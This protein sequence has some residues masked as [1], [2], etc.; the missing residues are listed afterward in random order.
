MS[1]YH[2]SVLAYIASIGSLNADAFAACFAADCELNDPVGAPV[3]HGQAGAHAFYSGIAQLLSKIEM[4]PVQVN[5][6]GNRAAF[7]WTMHA[8]GKAGQKAESAGID[9]LEFDEAG[10]IVRSWG[11][12]NPGPFVAALS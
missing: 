12:W 3:I 2:D 10:K 6:G 9:V 7:S 1:L 8:E 4:R 5:L 11:F